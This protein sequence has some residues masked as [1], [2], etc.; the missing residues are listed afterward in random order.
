MDSDWTFLAEDNNRGQKYPF[1]E[2]TGFYPGLINLFIAI[3]DYDEEKNDDE[4]DTPPK[5]W[6]GLHWGHPA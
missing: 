4:K 1:K 3:C 6:R 5:P 2:R